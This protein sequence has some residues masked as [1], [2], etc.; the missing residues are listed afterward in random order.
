M[1]FLS[2]IVCAIS[3]V[4]SSAWTNEIQSQRAKPQPLKKEV[5][6]TNTTFAQ[7]IWEALSQNLTPEVDNRIGFSE[8]TYNVD[9]GLSCS[10]QW[11]SGAPVRG[12]SRYK[13]SCVLL[14]D[15]GWRDMGSKTYGSGSNEKFSRSL[16]NALGVEEVV[17]EGLG[18]KAIELNVPDGEGGT[19]RNLLTCISPK[20]KK[21]KEFFRTSCSL[22]NAL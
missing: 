18:T 3:L 6:V 15:S 21:A 8:T 17:E 2:S 20:T 19:E 11:G 14:P 22:M 12:K 16:Y 9:M 1:K 10:R 4:S 5:E 7:L 13:F